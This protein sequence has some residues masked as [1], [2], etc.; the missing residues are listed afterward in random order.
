VHRTYSGCLGL[1]AM[2]T[3]LARGALQGAA[4]AEVVW[5]AWLALWCFAA[6]GLVA[7]RLAEWMV[8]E[9]VRARISEELA[10]REA[11]VAGTSLGGTTGTRSK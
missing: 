11:A 10:R 4:T 3:M 1:I 9:S 5:Q 7:G 2:L 6:I 8:D